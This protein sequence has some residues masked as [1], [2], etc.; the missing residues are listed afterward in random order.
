[1]DAKLAQK[2]AGALPVKC[3]IDCSIYAAAFSNYF[4]CNGC[5][6]PRQPLADVQDTFAHDAKCSGSALLQCSGCCCMYFCSREC[7]LNHWNAQLTFS[8]DLVAPWRHFEALKATRA[9]ARRLFRLVMRSVDPSW[10]EFNACPMLHGDAFGSIY[11][12]FQRDINNVVAAGKMTQNDAQ[13]VIRSVEPTG[14]VLHSV[15]LWILLLRTSDNAE[16]RAYVINMMVSLS[17]VAIGTD[18]ALCAVTNACK[19]WRQESTQKANAIQ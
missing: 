6:K 16:S 3:D 18:A 15:Q 8:C 11:A 12:A 10:K 7:Q 5:W 4:L 2:P 9:F 13:A 1:M 14:I 19:W 17:D